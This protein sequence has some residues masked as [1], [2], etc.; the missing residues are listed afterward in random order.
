MGIN[1]ITSGFLSRQAMNYLSGNLGILSGIQEKLASGRNINRPSDDPVAAALDAA[2]AALAKVESEVLKDHAAT[3]VA[4]AIAAGIGVGAVGGD[5][6]GRI[7]DVANGLTHLAAVGG[8][9]YPLSAAGGVGLGGGD[10]HARRSAE[11]RAGQRDE[12]AAIEREALGL[13]AGA[14]RMRGMPRG[15]R[16]GRSGPSG[17]PHLPPS[18]TISMTNGGTSFGAAA[19]VGAARGLVKSTWRGGHRLA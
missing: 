10:L 13:R 3:C 8:E 2:R 5:D 1:R 6:I 4:E 18:Q 19:V 14:R 9:H 7:D 17:G 16:A 15:D 12:L 11:Q